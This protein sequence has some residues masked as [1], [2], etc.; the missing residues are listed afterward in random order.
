M[1]LTHV[2]EPD[3]D[4][5]AKFLAFPVSKTNSDIGQA[6]FPLLVRA[7]LSRPSSCLAHLGRCGVPRRVPRSE[8][9]HVE[10]R[11]GKELRDLRTCAEVLREFGDGAVLQVRVRVRKKDVK[12]LVRRRMEYEQREPKERG[13]RVS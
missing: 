2:A 9:T 3:D 1:H 8:Q 4:R 5:Q 13:E 11:G 12:R 6:S 7:Q 10:G